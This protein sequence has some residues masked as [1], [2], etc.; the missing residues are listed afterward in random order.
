MKSN[1]CQ[2]KHHFI[3]VLQICNY[4]HSFYYCVPC[5]SLAYNCTIHV[6]KINAMKTTGFSF[7]VSV[8]CRGGGGG[9]GEFPYIRVQGIGV[10][11]RIP[12]SL[13]LGRKVQLC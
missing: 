10:L 7:P 5:I 9:G 6:S 2:L 12:P 8:W 4:M 13:P 3:L 11:I 1:E